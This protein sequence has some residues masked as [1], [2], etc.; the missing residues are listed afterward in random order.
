MGHWP[1]TDQ[2]QTI[3]E[4]FGSDVTYDNNCSGSVQLSFVMLIIIVDITKDCT[5]VK[6]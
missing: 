3:I 2:T 4:G 5:I 1:D 6:Q